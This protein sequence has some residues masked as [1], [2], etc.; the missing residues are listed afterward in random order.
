MPLTLLLRLLHEKFPVTLTADP[1]IRNASVL[2]A[3]GLIEAEFHFD[4]FGYQQYESAVVFAITDEGHAEIASLQTGHVAAA[5]GQ[6][7]PVMPLDYLRKIGNSVFP[8]RVDDPTEINSVAVLNAAGMVEAT[9][10]PACRARQTH[11]KFKQ[12]VVLRV[13]PLGQTALVARRMAALERAASGPVVRTERVPATNAL[14]V[15]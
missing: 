10:P 1:D 5:E 12:A 6:K 11:Q 8:L 2:L 7:W 14:L 3:T 13:T 15:D 9:L 4:H